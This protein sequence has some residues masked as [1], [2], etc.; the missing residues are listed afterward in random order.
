MERT[1]RVMCFWTESVFMSETCVR[2]LRRKIDAIEHEKILER[3]VC[4]RVKVTQ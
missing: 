1:L 2:S 4:D 3:K